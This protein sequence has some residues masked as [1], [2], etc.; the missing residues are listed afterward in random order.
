M[1][2]RMYRPAT[3]MAALQ[4]RVA[5]FARDTVE[6]NLQNAHNV[7]HSER[8]YTA[9]ENHFR[10]RVRS[11]QGTNHDLQHMAILE[12]LA[13]EI[14]HVDNNVFRDDLCVL[15]QQIKDRNYSKI[16]MNFRQWIFSKDLSVFVQR[17]V[18]LALD[19]N[20]FIL[21]ETRHLDAFI[22]N[23][24]RGVHVL[25]NRH[26]TMRFRLIMQALVRQ[27]SAKRDV[28]HEYLCDLFQE[29]VRRHPN[30]AVADGFDFKRRV[31]T[32]GLGSL[33]S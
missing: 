18:D 32:P 28:F 5:D 19:H 27:I 20:H 16:D 17:Q 31:Q 7:L 4:E 14:R 24:Y 9:L 26:Q 15:F 23:F 25:H 11:L 29:V 13:D 12:A 6:R 33:F 10:G 22:H 21:H 8:E 2:L 1:Y 3:G 30:P